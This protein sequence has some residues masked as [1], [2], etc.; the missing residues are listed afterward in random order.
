M[1]NLS[2]RERARGPAGDVRGSAGVTRVLLALHRVLGAGE[3]V[4]LLAGPGLQQD[5]TAAVLPFGEQR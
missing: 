1:V 3:G 2:K 5:P 4:G